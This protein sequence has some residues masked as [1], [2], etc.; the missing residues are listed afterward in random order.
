MLENDFVIIP[1]LEPDEKLAQTVSSLKETGFSNIIVIDDGSGEAFAKFFPEDVILLRHEVN[2]G[3]GAAMKTAFK[4]ILENFPNARS[5]VAADA[6]GQHLAKDVLACVNAVSENNMVLGCRNFDL[7]N[8]PKRSRFGNHTTSRVF[9]WLCGIKISDTQTGLRAYPASL[10]PFLLTIEG[11]RY[12]YETNELLRFKQEGYGFTEVPIETVYI[13]QNQTSHFRVFRD[14]CRVY[15]FVLKFAFSSIFACLIDLLIFLL[16]LLFLGEPLGI[17]SKPV[18]TFIA[19]AISSFVNFNINRKKIFDAKNN[20]AKSFLRYYLIAI[21]QMLV[22]AALVTFFTTIA[23]SG[24]FGSTVIK[25]LV[26]IVLFFLSYRFQQT[27]VFS[28]K[29][30]NKK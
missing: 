17:I 28:N 15:S 24:A 3:K 1:A 6:D 21:P 29:K 11:E 7:E 18:C 8:V 30:A 20:Y 4:Y 25:A 27:F 2:K 22:S 9:K 5:V 10:L 16:S 23:S 13:E 19:R 12:E 26:D 14:S